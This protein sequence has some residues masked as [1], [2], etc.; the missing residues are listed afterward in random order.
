M[1]P[2]MT[3]FIGN[4]EGFP[5][6]ERVING[7]KK[8]EIKRVTLLPLMV[9]A[10]D[11]ASNDMAGNEKDSWK[12]MFESNGITVIPIMRGLGEMDEWAALYIKHLQDVMTAYQF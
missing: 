8:A 7:L 1:N 12:S 6:P 2:D 11:H 3:I 5:Q 10:G 4:V 9:V